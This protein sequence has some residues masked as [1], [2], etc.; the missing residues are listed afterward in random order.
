[1]EEW[2][3]ALNSGDYGNFAPFVSRMGM[4][5]PSLRRWPEGSFE[6][7]GVGRRRNGFR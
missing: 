2:V 6:G 5:S 1:M 3:T 4:E 7:R